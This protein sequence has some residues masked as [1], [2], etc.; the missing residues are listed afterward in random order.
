MRVPRSAD[1]TCAMFRSDWLIGV[2]A[3]STL[4]EYKSGALRRRSAPLRALE[5]VSDS[6]WATMSL[7]SVG[8]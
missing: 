8:P 2:S 5:P 1:I 3:Y 6:T 4:D 7:L